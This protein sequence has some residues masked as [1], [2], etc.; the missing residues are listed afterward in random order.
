MPN[1]TLLGQVR[2]Y[3]FTANVGAFLAPIYIL[4]RLMSFTSSAGAGKSV[5]W[6][7]NPSKFLFRIVEQCYR[8]APQLYR[9]SSRVCPGLP[10]WHSFIA[11]SGKT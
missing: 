5:L 11:T 7:V 2:S 8:P 9:I 4:W 1:G 10:H 6:Y 3:G